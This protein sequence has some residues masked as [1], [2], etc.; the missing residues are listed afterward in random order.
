MVSR[1]PDKWSGERRPPYPLGDSNS[2]DYKPA[3]MG[4]IDERTQRRTHTM[5]SLKTFSPAHLT[6][7]AK[8]SGFFQCP[9]CGLI[10]FGRPDIDQCPQGSHGRPVHVA[11]LCRT[12]D[13][14]VRVERFAAHIADRTH[15]VGVE[16]AAK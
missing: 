16:L 10:W 11:V 14:V 8:R 12:C 6:E 9:T 3:T 7:D 2:N 15:Q 4:A 5:T 1:S 13:V